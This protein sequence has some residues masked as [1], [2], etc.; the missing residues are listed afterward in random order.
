MSSDKKQTVA[1]LLADAELGIASALRYESEREAMGNPIP[2]ERQH[3][4]QA[5]HYMKRYS[6]VYRK[7]QELMRENDELSKLQSDP[8]G[9][10]K[11][12]KV[13]LQRKM[14]TNTIALLEMKAECKGFLDSAIDGYK[15]MAAGLPPG[16]KKSEWEAKIRAMEDKRKHED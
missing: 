8:N 14:V 2:K 11:S 16:K 15:V 1:E 4:T 3:A 13:E 5:I 6:Q 12:E 7:A 10:S 9:L